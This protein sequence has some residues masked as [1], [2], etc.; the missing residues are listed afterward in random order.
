MDYHYYFNEAL[1]WIY[2]HSKDETEYARAL[3]SIVRSESFV[4]EDLELNCGLDE[5]EIRT[6]FKKLDLRIPDEYNKDDEWDALCKK[7]KCNHDDL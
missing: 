3:Y 2:D 4:W 6:I 1:G 7:C 5:D